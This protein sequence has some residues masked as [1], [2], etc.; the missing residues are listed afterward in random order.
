MSLIKKQKFIFV[1]FVLF[2]AQQGYAASGNLIDKIFWGKLY[3]GGGKT[4]YCEQEF[5]RKSAIY[6]IDYIYTADKIGEFVGCTN[7]IQCKRDKKYNGII[8]DL[9]NMVPAVK[10][11]YLKRRT[12][13]FGE[14]DDDAH[15][16]FDEYQCDYKT[17]FQIVDPR[18][19]VKGNVARTM[20]YM[21][22][23]YGL[24]FVGHLEM[25]QRWSD[26]DP[27]D[28]AERDRNDLIE[29]LQGKRNRYIDNPELAK[30]LKP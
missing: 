30:E 20:F 24:P 6:A 26:L 12:T 16:A 2:S 9:H 17:V 19:G 13:I 27:V 22:E 25:Y 3:S 5:K 8:S 29:Q 11:V 15:K 7:R 23:E 10:K 4:F 21:H 1:L 28:Q 14:I 18:N